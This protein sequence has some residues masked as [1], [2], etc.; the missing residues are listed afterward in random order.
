MFQTDG[1]ELEKVDSFTY[2]GSVLTKNGREDEDNTAR[3]GKANAAFVQLYSNWKSRGFLK[4]REE[5]E[6][7]VYLEKNC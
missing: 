2:L 1:K 5:E 6:G 3:I 4:D 7:L